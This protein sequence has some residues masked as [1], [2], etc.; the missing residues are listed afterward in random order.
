MK[1]FRIVDP[2][3]RRFAEAALRGTWSKPAHQCQHCERP[4]SQRV[5]PLIIEWLPGST[6]IGHFVWPG[7]S[8]DVA[9]TD[10]VAREIRERFGGFELREL[11]FVGSPLP[12]R[13]GRR[14]GTGPAVVPALFDVWITK[15][16][17][18]GKESLPGSNLCAVCCREDYTL[19]AHGQAVIDTIA[20]PFR[21]VQASLQLSDSLVDP[22][23]LFRIIQ[24]PGAILCTEE[25][26]N[27][28]Q[29]S[30]FTNIAFWEVGSLVRL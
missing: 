14:E 12:K 23:E 17:D 13:K 25:F 10:V 20:A 18:A 19:Q 24:V 30:Y 9:V 7:F 4:P 3:D 28:V 8:N 5:P 1:I 2:A 27:F 29:K 22:H 6:Q 26:K 11:N 16:I 21:E 15:W